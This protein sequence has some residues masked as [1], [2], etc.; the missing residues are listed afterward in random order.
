MAVK[1]T[2][3]KKLTYYLQKSITKSGFS[4]YYFSSKKNGELVN[5]IPQG[6]E[7]F[8]NPNGRVYLRK[9][10]P[11]QITKHE[12]HIVND[13]M[14]KFSI[15]NYSK[16]VIK[17][18]TIII[19]TSD[20]N[21]DEAIIVLKSFRKF[22]KGE[23]ENY[24]EKIIHYSPT[25]KFVL[26]DSGNRIFQ[27]KRYCYL[28]SNNDWIDIGASGKLDKLVKKYVRHLGKESYFELQ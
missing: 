3:S 13:G 10:Q 19:Y 27:T 12:E 5:Q 2:N 9:A 25:L 1:Y 6:Y 26:V 15:L 8:E 28:G 24:I 11:T 20:Q 23:L 7:I 22:K 16:L 18:D 21:I 17:K 14:N 4:K